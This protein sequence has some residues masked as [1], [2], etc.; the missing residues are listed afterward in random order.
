MLFGKF[1]FKSYTYKNP[2]RAFIRKARQFAACRKIAMRQSV[3]VATHWPP[4]SL[5]WG[6]VLMQGNH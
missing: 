3:G 4:A 1:R 6:G 2:Y 5:G